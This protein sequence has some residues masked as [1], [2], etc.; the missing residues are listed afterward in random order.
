[1]TTLEPPQSAPTA[2]GLLQSIN[3]FPIYS[4]PDFIDLQRHH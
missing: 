2:A 1:M 4:E 3:I